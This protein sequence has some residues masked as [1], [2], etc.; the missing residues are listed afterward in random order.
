VRVVLDTSTLIAAHISRAGVCS[1]LFE[2]ILLHHELVISEYI[3]EEL[4][5]KL[6]EKFGFP[7]MDV[8]AVSRFLRAHAQLVT[9]DQLPTSACRD[10]KDLPVLGTATA[11]TAALLITV[12]RDLLELTEFGG[13][14]IIKPGQYWQRVEP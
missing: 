2:E 11:G 4:E 14:A 9:P 5:R 8:R 3:L 7:E 12:D 10:T 6:E 13:I 1:E